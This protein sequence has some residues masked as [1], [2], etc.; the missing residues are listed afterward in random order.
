[1]ARMAVFMSSVIWFL[2]LMA[3]SWEANGTW[4]GGTAGQK[5]GRGRFPWRGRCV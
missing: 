3:S 2:R 1:L 5:Q 4:K